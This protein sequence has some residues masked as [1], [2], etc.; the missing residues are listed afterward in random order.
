LEAAAALFG[1]VSVYLSTRE[2]VAAWPT[3]LVNVALYAIIF[4]DQRLYADMGLQCVYFVLSLYGWYQ[5]KFGGTEHTALTVSRASYR[6]LAILFVLNIAAWL[7]LGAFLD[8]STDAVLPYLDSLLTT[9][10]L[11]AQ[12]LMTRKVLES[13]ALWIAVDVIY[14]PMFVSRGLHLTAVL[15]ALFLG[16][17]FKGWYD[18]KRSLVS[19]TTAQATP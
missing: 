13:W 10:S 7:S 9:T 4:R 12:Y 18:W 3:A 16:L 5:W 14:V 15:Y 2:R 11:V 19:V 8:R 17:A 6:T 1:V